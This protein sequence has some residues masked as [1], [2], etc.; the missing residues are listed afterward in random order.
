MLASGTSAGTAKQELALSQEGQHLHST[1]QE[2]DLV[3]G[4][5]ADSHSQNL[6]LLRLQ[7]SCLTPEFVRWKRCQ[8]QSLRP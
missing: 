6:G 4:L 7:D 5:L 2:F 3:A 8:R 1:G